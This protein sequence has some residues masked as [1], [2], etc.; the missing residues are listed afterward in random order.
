[1][2]CTA[3]YTPPP[4]VEG[5]V[6]VTMTPGVAQRLRAL[7]CN[8]NGGVFNELEEALSELPLP[9]LSMFVEG[10]KPP[11]SEWN[12]GRD[13]YLSINLHTGLAFKPSDD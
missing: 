12:V 1:M 2:T 7:L 3:I 4:V 5:S 10:V 8:C 11:S 13:R 6:T 9:K